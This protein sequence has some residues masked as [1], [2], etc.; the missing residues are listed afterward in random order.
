M[1]WNLLKV[2]AKQAQGKEL[3]TI[4]GISE[5]V[6]YGKDQGYGTAEVTSKNRK[7]LDLWIND[8]KQN[9]YELVI[10][11]IPPKL[12]HANTNFYGGLR[13]YLDSKRLHYYDLT[14]P[15]HASKKRS[16]ELYWLNDGH[17]SNDG[18]I[19]VG[20]FLAEKLK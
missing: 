2:G 16:E 3:A 18:N 4:Y 15:F 12:H 19:F 20:K 17:L 9:N 1:T 8:A 5:G 6:N 7:G 13:D 11:L 14:D 10:I